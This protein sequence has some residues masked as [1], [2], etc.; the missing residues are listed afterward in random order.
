MCAPGCGGLGCECGVTLVS[1]NLHTVPG[2]RVLA[3]PLPRNRINTSQAATGHSD[4]CARDLDVTPLASYCS[5]TSVGGV[6]K[7]PTLLGLLHVV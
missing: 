3:P 7:L 4:T 2:A 6:R 1:I 5:W